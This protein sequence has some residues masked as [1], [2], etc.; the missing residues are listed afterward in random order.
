MRRR[1]GGARRFRARRHRGPR[2]PVIL[3]NTPTECGAACLAMVLGAHGRH[4]PSRRLREEMDVGRDGA[5][6]Q[7]LALTAERHGMRVRAYQAEPEALR[8]MPVPVIVHWGLSHFVVVEAVDDRHA[9]IVDPASGRER[10]TREEFDRSFTGI[11]LAML[12]GEDF[13]RIRPQT[14]EVPRFLARHLPRTPGLFGAVVAV[15][16]LLTA[17]G[18]L[19]ALATRYLIDRVVPAGGNDLMAVVGLGVAALVVGQALVGFLRSEALVRLRLRVDLSLMTSFLGHLFRLPYTYFQLRSSGD[20]L[21]RVSSGMVIRDALSSHALSLVLDSA[22]TVL[23]V[24]LLWFLSPVIGAIVL[25]AAVLQLLAVGLFS[26]RVRE[27]SREEISAVAEAHTQLVESLAGAETLKSAGAEQTALGRWE[28]LYRNQLV[29]TLRK[30]TVT[31]R[32]ELLLDLFR[33]GTPLLLLWTG[34]WFVLGGGMSLGTLVAANTLAA[35]ALTPVTSLSQIYHS[36]QSAAVHVRRLQDVFQE[37]TEQEGEP[38]PALAGA[39]E[40]RGVSY[41][42]QSSA[43]EAVSDVDLSVPAGSMVAV[44]GRSGS[45]KSTLGRLMLGL[46]QPTR[47]SVGFDGIPLE[48]LDLRSVR[49]QCGVV[50]QDNAVFSGS[51]LDNIRVNTPEASVEE[52]LLASRS[53][54]LHEDVEQMPL[55]Y[56]TPLGERGSGLSGGQRQRIGLARALVS[57]PRILLLDEAT[58]HLDTVTERRVQN[59]LRSLE[60][61]RVVI[62]HRLSTIREADRIV[63]IADGCVVEQGT[64]TELVAARGHYADLVGG[65]LTEL[66]AG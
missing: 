30:D 14:G 23:Y 2:V 54:C 62:A 17:L 40:L 10:I 24:T 66:A 36:L 65:D 63:V 60:C 51:I 42:Y 45:G 38:A 37:E 22:M 59:H 50:V 33:L 31:N 56:F 39:I 46:Y 13:E 3:Q 21:T 16:L 64:H 52:V 5:S 25:G 11:V 6:A 12:P 34:T 49:A 58:S 44:V 43:E 48:G 61:T 7:A 32:L 29:S 9:H 41:R 15:S 35:M 18:V 8:V 20:L 26:R 27:T 4:V 53:A 47:G 55:G 57:R 19:P 1:T 28:W